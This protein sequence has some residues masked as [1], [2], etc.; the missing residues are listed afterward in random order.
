[1]NTH[2]KFAFSV[3][4]MISTSALANTTIE[5]Y[6]SPTCGCCSEW[7]E[8]MEEKGYTVNVHHKRDWSDVKSQFGMPPQLQ[9]CHTAIIGGYLIEGHVPEKEIARLLRER[10]TD[11]KGIAAP[12]MP[13]FS[14]GMAQPGEE[15]K[16]FKVISYSD[17]GFA[18]YA[19]Y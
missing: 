17:D 1:M 15:Y 5:L 11:I 14:P 19:E 4:A 2:N 10:P 18:V 12:G 7:V 8:I 3:L 13:R 16:D 9:S 6:K